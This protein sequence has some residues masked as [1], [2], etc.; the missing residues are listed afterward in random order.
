MKNRSGS[1]NYEN[2]QKRKK[3]IEGQLET[4]MPKDFHF[5]KKNIQE[6]EELSLSLNEAFLA[7]ES[8][9]IKE[10]FENWGMKVNEINEDNVSFTDRNGANMVTTKENAN[11]IIEPA[12]MIQQAN[13]S[14]SKVAFGESDIMN[15]YKDQQDLQRGRNVASDDMG[16]AGGN[17]NT[18]DAFRNSTDAIDQGVDA[19]S[20]DDAM[21][22]A[23]SDLEK[24]LSD[25][26]EVSDE[27]LDAMDAK[28]MA[29]DDI[30]ADFF[31]P[32]ERGDIEDFR[33]GIETADDVDPNS[34]EMKKARMN[35]LAR[36]GQMRL[37]KLN[38]ISEL[39]NFNGR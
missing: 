33:T 38:K 2:I 32:N 35:N 3:E 1:V 29:S 27:F 28:D 11:D 4:L 37:E 36:L 34:P 22:M 8:E 31:E 19:A 17:I 14:E 6:K 10:K 9:K 16:Q 7:T 12:I 25:L 39:K 26:E 18:F 23:Y 13:L 15:R 30:G 5:P 20:D 21:Q 24:Q